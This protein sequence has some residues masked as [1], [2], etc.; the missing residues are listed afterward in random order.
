[1]KNVPDLRSEEDI[2]NQYP[3]YGD[4][5]CDENQ[6]LLDGETD[7]C[8][9]RLVMG[10]NFEAMLVK[11]KIQNVTV[12]QLF[13]STSLNI[14]S[15]TATSYC[16]EVKP[17]ATMF[18]VRSGVGNGVEILV[19]LETFDNADLE[20]IGNGM[21][22][23]VATASDYPLEKLNG[24]S[25]GPGSAVD[26]RIHPVLY[27]ITTPALTRFNYINR[28]CIDPKI[29]LGTNSLDGITGPYSLSNCLISAVISQIYDR[30]DAH[31][32]CLT[33]RR[34]CP[35][36]SKQGTWGIDSITGSKGQLLECVN[37]YMNR[38]GLVF[39]SQCV[40]GI[41]PILQCHMGY[42]PYGRAL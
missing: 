30:Q 24:R 37:H 3:D 29:D 40:S 1:M 23:L 8:W 2:L 14:K 13:N 34:R 12:P 9:E 31:S 41:W 7:P 6:K 22:I 16:A 25:I 32:K 18:P 35:S 10:Q 42:M 33:T 38:V 28:K 17:D 15:T 36:L 20:V 21:D 39:I 4:E 19:D 5:V 27:N 26:I 11:L